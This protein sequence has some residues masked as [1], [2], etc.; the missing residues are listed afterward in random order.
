MK[1]RKRRVGMVPLW[2]QRGRYFQLMFIVLDC[3]F[4]N[5]DVNYPQLRCAF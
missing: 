1:R 3:G 5:S 4:G 2:C